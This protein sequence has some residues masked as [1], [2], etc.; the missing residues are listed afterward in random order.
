[1]TI[2]IASTNSKRRTVVL[3]F[4]GTAD[5]FSHMNTNVVKLFSLLK[6]DSIHDQICYYQAGIGMYYQPGVV[7]PL[8][9]KV[10]QLA[11]EATAWYLSQHVMDGYRFLMQNYNVGDK[12]CLFGFSRGAYIARA[13][14]GMLHKVGLLLKDNLEQVPFA[15]KLYKSREPLK[16]ELANSFKKSFSREVPI[17]FVGVWDT[18]ASV[19]IVLGRSLPFVDTNTTIKTFRQALSLDED[20]ARFRPSLWSH[21]ER[22]QPAFKSSNGPKND[23]HHQNGHSRSHGSADE[24]FITDVKEVW[25]AG[26]HS[27]VGGGSV[28]DRADHSLANIPLRWMVREIMLAQCGILFDSAALHRWKIPPMVD[29]LLKSPASEGGP[30]TPVPR[31]MTLHSPTTNDAQDY[32][33]I[34]N[35]TMN[36][37]EDSQLDAQDATQPI[38]DELKS[39]PVWWLLEI[40]P[41]SYMRHTVQ[42]KWVH[43]WS[44]HFGRGRDVPPQPLFHD[45]VRIRMEDPKLKYKP[46][47]KYAVGTET[48]VS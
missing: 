11:D 5:E 44:I 35:S 34:N 14:A 27:D 19:G 15:Y 25:F 39:T 6:K 17:E 43:H 42:G 30:I 45:S 7:S 10:A 9:R 22:R 33:T 31:Q 21:P 8:F 24:R 41:T 37:V 36:L 20:R 12:V 3:C 46:K 26:C 47:A 40:I 2:P 29:D 28:P 23:P 16:V 48:Y 38:H 4:D 32:E 18:V 1:M 13:L